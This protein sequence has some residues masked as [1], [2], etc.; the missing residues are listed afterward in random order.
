MSTY[1]ITHAWRLDGY[2]VVQTLEDLTG[3]VDGSSFSITGLNP[4]LHLNGSHTV[5]S[6]S[7]GEFLGVND[8][9]D[10]L[11]DYDYDYPNQVIFPDA[12]DDSAR[13]PDSGTL[14]YT[15][16]CTWISSANVTEWLGISSATANDTAFITKCVNAANAYASR[17]RREAGYFDSLSS[18]PSNDV[19]LG[20]IMYAGTLYRERGSV[21]SFASFDQL[22]TAAPF[23]SM[24][25]IKQLLGVG[26]PQVG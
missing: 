16:T 12:G 1:T 17:V 3:L 6:L 18:V 4:D 11:F 25:R 8:E 5:W 22:G 15:P 23:G 19:L 14:T 13:A 2:G 10:L 7:N 24:G 20:T 9:G 21:D 26:R